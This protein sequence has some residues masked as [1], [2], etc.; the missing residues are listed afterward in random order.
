[1]SGTEAQ[2][3]QRVGGVAFVGIEHGQRSDGLFGAGIELDRGLEFGFGFLQV[4][5]QAVQTAEKQMVINIVGFELD[6]LFVLLDRQLK[7]VIGAGAAGHI[8]QRAQINSAQQLVRFQ[9]LGI[10][11]DDVLG[12]EHG[13]ANPAGLNVKFG[14]SGGQEFR[15][16]VGVDGQAV[17]LNGFVGQIAAAI[18]CDLL[19]IHV[20]ERVVI[21]GS[22]AVEFVGRRLAAGLLESAG[23]DCSD[24]LDWS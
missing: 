15:R 21:V 10:A 20:G 5:V 4:V 3:L 18:G 17:F 19:F 22:G 24:G 8:A 7:H 16:R 6:D 14:K 11:L 2:H 13:V 9:I 1:M 12:F 23:L